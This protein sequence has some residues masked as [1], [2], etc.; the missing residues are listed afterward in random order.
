MQ[1]KIDDCSPVVNPRHMS[2]NKLCA[3]FH[4]VSASSTTIKNIEK[5]A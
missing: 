2:G 3:K 5:T 1:Y 4:I